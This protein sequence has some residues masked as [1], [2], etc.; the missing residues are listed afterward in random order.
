MTRLERFRL[1][2]M[3]TAGLVLMLSLISHGVR[4]ED[5]P[6]A[7]TVTYTNMQPAFVVN[8]GTSQ[9]AR[10]SFAKVEVA[11]RIDTATEAPRVEKHM[12]ALRH[13]L[14][15]LLSKQSPDQ[16]GG[17]DGQENARLEALQAVQALLTAEEGAPLVSDLLFTSFVV[18][19]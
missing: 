7:P 18:Q 17:P 6:P 12:P 9:T 5:P 8:I 13:A 3:R 4:A 2:G 19:R 16:L 1:P 10:L 11:L 14:V 15:M